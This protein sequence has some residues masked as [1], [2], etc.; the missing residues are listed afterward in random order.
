MKLLVS[1]EIKDGN[2]MN[3]LHEEEGKVIQ[4]ILT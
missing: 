1:G 4:F 2:I 3:S